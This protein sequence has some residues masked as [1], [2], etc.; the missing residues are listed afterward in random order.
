[1]NNQKLISIITVSYNDPNGLS[2]TLESL[3]PL[4]ESNLPWEHIIVDS[5]PAQHEAVLNADKSLWP[6]VYLSEPPS[7]IYS[8]MN[9]GWRN[10]RGLTLLFLNSG[11]RLISAEAL[12]KTMT[13]F[14]QDLNLDIF[15]G[16]VELTRNDESLYNQF[17]H[18]SFLKNI[19]GANHICHQAAI[20]RRSSFEKI[21]DFSKS[22]KLASDYEHHFRCYLGGLNL[23]VSPST[24]LVKFDVSGQSSHYRQVLN[25]Y[26][27]I[28]R[29][30]AAQLPHHLNILNYILLKI[31]TARLAA[32]KK[33]SSSRFS[34]TLRPLWLLWKRSK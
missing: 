24:L 16:G 30:V 3:R 12:K 5:S 26:R 17:H 19:L 18:S 23:K 22:Y 9:H 15:L 7:G 2:Q 34:E 8:A 33:A 32:V 20:Y 21:G 10:A 13:E 4:L 11:D 29:A 1:M 14:E 25:E 28:H 27:E 6:R 31:E